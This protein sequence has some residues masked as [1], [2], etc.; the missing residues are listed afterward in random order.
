MPIVMALRNPDMNETHFADINELIG[1]ELNFKEDGFT[2]QSL[3][4]MNVVQFM[5]QIV[6]KSVE[7]TGQAKLRTA[8]KELKDIWASQEFLCKNYKERDNQFILIGIDELYQ[9]LDESIAQIN[10]ILGNRYVKVMRQEAETMKKTLNM[11]QETVTLWVDCQR[12]WCYL[13]NI[14]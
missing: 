9:V 10:M 8:L 4:D 11:L 13:E 12:Q 6:A 1:Q 2:L 7:A 5:E 14:F 3:I